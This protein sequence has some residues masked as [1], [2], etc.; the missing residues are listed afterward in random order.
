VSWSDIS[1]DGI[2][3]YSG[4]AMYER[5]FSI[6]NEVLASGKQAFVL[7]GDVQEMVRVHVNG[8]D[9]GIIWTPPYKANITPYLKAGQNKIT[10]Q[11]IN[12]WNNRIVGDLNKPSEKYSNTNLN[13]KFKANGPLLKSGLMGKA[14]IQFLNVKNQ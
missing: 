4:S 13:S 2:K 6:T 8:K 7:F 14:E 9:C 5:E 10:V 11:V 1:H 12:A 3:Y